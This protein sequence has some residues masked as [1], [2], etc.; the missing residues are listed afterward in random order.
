MN[1]FQRLCSVRSFLLSRKLHQLF[2]TGSFHFR[3]GQAKLS[4]AYFYSVHFLRVRHFAG[5][6]DNKPLPG[7]FLETSFPLQQTFKTVLSPIFIWRGTS[8]DF[9]SRLAASQPKKL[10]LLANELVKLDSAVVSMALSSFS[11]F[12]WL[13]QEPLSLSVNFEDHSLAAKRFCRLLLSWSR[14]RKRTSSFFYF[15]GIHFQ[16]PG[17]N[18]EHYTCKPRFLLNCVISLVQHSG[19][20]I[21]FDRTC[22][23]SIKI[24]SIQKKLLHSISLHRKNIFSW[25]FFLKESS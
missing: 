18:S 17:K 6:I 19:T 22:Q 13:Q 1:N 14:G 15:G 8:R 23:R 21:K 25:N 10:A 2:A 4:Q 16:T 9:V 7:V 11:H 24:I 20:R 12:S 5:K 3:T